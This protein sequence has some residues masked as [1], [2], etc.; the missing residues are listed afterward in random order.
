[1]PDEPEEPGSGEP[2]AGPTFE[3]PHPNGAVHQAKPARTHAPWEFM[4]LALLV[5][6]LGIGIVLGWTLVGSHS[7]EHLDTGSAAAVS[8]VCDHAQAKLKE[9]PQPFPRLGADRVARVRAENAV[10]RA[11]VNQF[12]TVHPASK[13]PASALQG[14]SADWGRMLDARAR[15]ADDLARVAGTNT[16]VR[17]IYPAVNAIKPITGRMDDFVRENHPRL[18]ACFTEALQLEVVEGPRDYKKVTK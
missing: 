10:L 7:P 11:M 17:L 4:M 16:K 18:D 9:L 1:M 6:V 14:W 8:A 3:P 13:T 15:Y 2:E 5:A 12:A